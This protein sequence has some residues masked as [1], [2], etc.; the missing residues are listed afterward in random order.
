MVH[1][2]TL[3]TTRSYRSWRGPDP[4]TQTG[5]DPSDAVR[6]EEHGDFVFPCQDRAGEDDDDDW[7]DDGEELVC[8]IQ[9]E[10]CDNCG[11]IITPG[12][13]MMASTGITCNGSP[14][15]NMFDDMCYD[16]M[17]DA[18]GDHASRYHR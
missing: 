18:D 15:D 1:A 13:A 5:P 17:A 11:T 6:S 12:T 10:H 14:G 4:G 7:E 9:E 8:T 3:S 2:L 16:L